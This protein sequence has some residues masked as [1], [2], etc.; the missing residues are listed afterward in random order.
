MMNRKIISPFHGKPTTELFTD[1]NG[2]TAFRITP[3]A[4]TPQRVKFA[5][6]LAAMS[7]LGL[8]WGGFQILS[9]IPH[10][11]DWLWPALLLGPWLSYPIL[12]WLWRCIL[13]TETRIEM[14][15]D[16]FK[17]RSWSGWKTYDRKLPHKLSLI[18]HDKAQEE[19]DEHDLTI[20]QGQP[21]I[22]KRYFGDSYHLSYDYL[23]QRNDVL[24]VFGY[25]DALTILARLK[26]CDERL[27]QLA[28]MGDGIA[29]DPEEQWDN[30]PGGI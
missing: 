29:L 12:N 13:Q 28:S 10:P 27:D 26:A 4:I 14:T 23:G 11:E 3:L 1:K 7:A 6:F 21:T 5:E 15:T 30:Q 18:P 19:K 17:F 24:T 8:S 20:R 9:G 16:E 25:K 2:N 22:R